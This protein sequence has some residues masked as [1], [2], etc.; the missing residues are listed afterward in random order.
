MIHVVTPFSRP[1]FLPELIRN[2]EGQSVIWHPITFKQ[3]AFPDADWIVP[4]EVEPNPD[5][6]CPCYWKLKQF[7]ETYRLIDA[8]YYRFQN[9]DDLFC[10]GFFAE[11]AKAAGDVVFNSMRFLP[12]HDL[13]G[14]EGNIG[15]GITGLEQFQ[16]RGHVLR[17]IKWKNLR[18]ADGEVAE[19]LVREFRCQYLPDAWTHFNALRPLWWKDVMAQD[20]YSEADI[21]GLYERS[22]IPYP[23]EQES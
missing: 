21:M 19:Y 1:K 13:P 14:A 4:V 22:G 11:I 3:T 15:R 6:W 23:V 16:V 9:D 8:D 12:C 5:G 2:M 10:P 7:T 17:T 20:R 18:D